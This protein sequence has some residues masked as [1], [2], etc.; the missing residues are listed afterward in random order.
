M[1][2]TIQCEYKSLSDINKKQGIIIVGDMNLDTSIDN[3]SANNY[4]DMCVSH[5][6]HCL[7][8]G[9][10]REDEHGRSRTC[11]TLTVR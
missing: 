8:T 1:L 11:S 5:G 6:L 10:T 3:G 9:K 4:L 7:I 2:Q